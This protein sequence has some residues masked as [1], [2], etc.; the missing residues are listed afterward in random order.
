[1]STALQQS[2]N[3][4]APLVWT[5]LVEGIRRNDADSMDQ[6]YRS[7]NRGVRW[8]VSRQ[9]GPQDVEDSVHDCIAAAIG[10]I[11]AGTIRE[12]ERLAGFVQTIVKRHIAQR[13]AERVSERGSRRDVEDDYLEATAVADVPSPEDVA[14]RNEIRQIARNVLAAMKPADREVLRRFYLNDQPQEQICE[15]LAIPQQQFRNVKHRA[16]Q[17]FADLCRAEMMPARRG[18]AVMGPTASCALAA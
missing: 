7:F 18:P 13:I 9:L 2:P 8:F 14:G 12:P 15:E 4:P 16:K 17:R 1:M 11:Q 3:E 5:S 10:A 6:F